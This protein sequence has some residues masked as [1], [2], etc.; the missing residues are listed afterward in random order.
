MLRLTQQSV[1][2]DT[3]GG[4]SPPYRAK[5]VLNMMNLH[6]IKFCALC[7]FVFLCLCCSAEAEVLY[8]F[9]GDHFYKVVKD[10]GQFL[11]KEKS[12]ENK[13]NVE[14]LGI[15]EHTID[16]EDMFVSPDER[17]FVFAGAE[18]RHAD[19]RWFLVD[20][21]ECKVVRELAIGNS[22]YTSYYYNAAFSPDSKKLYVSWQVVS[23]EE[24]EETSHYFTKEYSGEGFVQER[25]L[26]NVFIPM[27]FGTSGKPYRFTKDGSQILVH[28]MTSQWYFNITVYDVQKD[29]EVF[30]TS[31]IREYV[32]KDVKLL[33]QIDENEYVPYITNGQILFNFIKGKGVEAR[34]F[35]YRDKKIKRRFEVP[36]KAVGRF[37]NEGRR[38]VF[39]EFADPKTKKKKV[40]VFEA[41]T[42]KQI[43]KTVID[44]DNEVLDVSADGKEIIYKRNGKVKKIP[45]KKRGKGK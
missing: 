12:C 15:S 24:G 44:K 27:K 2:G 4:H 14:E 39:T 13:I 3:F 40:I 22:V 30:R 42:G 5:E 34:I 21:K 25:V 8:S 36:S 45:L 26:K 32:G 16:P 18:G 1:Q 29:A 20:I 43:G 28:S 35:D 10:D 23:R 19:R 33:G 37:A 7:G 31:D 38:V 9:R 17:F 6:A 41:N 11:S